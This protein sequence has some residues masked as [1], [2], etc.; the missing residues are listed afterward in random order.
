MLAIVHAMPH[1]GIVASV[2]TYSESMIK[3][4]L[5]TLRWSM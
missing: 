1:A 2:Q 3:V 4:N 5:V